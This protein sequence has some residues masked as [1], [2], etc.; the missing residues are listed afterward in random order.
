M[1]P[2]NLQTAVV[3]RRNLQG[4]LVNVANGQICMQ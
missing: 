1:V 2:S 3:C 4:H